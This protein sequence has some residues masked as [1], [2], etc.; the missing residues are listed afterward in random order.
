MLVNVCVKCQ[1]IGVRIHVII[2]LYINSLLFDQNYRNKLIQ[3]IDIWV[4][5][6]NY[7]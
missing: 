4:D 5:I 6:V 2:A 1:I 7:D 3:I